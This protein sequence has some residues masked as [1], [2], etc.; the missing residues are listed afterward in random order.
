MPTRSTPLAIGTIEPS[1]G[2]VLHTVP[3]GYTTIVQWIAVSTAATT[4][5][6]LSFYVDGPA[7][8]AVGAV[9]AVAGGRGQTDVW[10]PLWPGWD[11]QAINY[12]AAPISFLIGGSVLPGIAD[13][14]DLVVSLRDRTRPRPGVLPGE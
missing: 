13:A 5:T 7:Y 3:T 12:A 14:V 8:A 9:D 11:L 6:S 1:E 4:P 10:W 2:L